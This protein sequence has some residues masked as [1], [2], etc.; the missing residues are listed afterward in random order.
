[1]SKNQKKNKKS[2]K[3]K[4]FKRVKLVEG[5]YYGDYIYA[6]PK[7]GKTTREKLND[8]RGCKDG[9]YRVKQ[10]KKGVKILLCITEKQGKRGGHTKA[11]SIIRD[12]IRIKQYK[13]H[14]QKKEPELIK[15]LKKKEKIKEKL[16]KKS[17][18]TKKK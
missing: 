16:T 15:A 4:E 17:K 1:M 2:T 18:R 6:Y 14:Y 3:K 11:L 12:D 7:T 8:K 13:K 9:E 10:V 5:G